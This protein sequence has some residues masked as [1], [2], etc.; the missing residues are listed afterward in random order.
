MI[1]IN[2]VSKA[3]LSRWMV[4]ASQMLPAL[5]GQ[6]FDLITPPAQAAA[7]SCSRLN[8]DVCGTKWYVGGWDGTKGL[9]Q[10]LSALDTIQGLLVKDMQPPLIVPDSR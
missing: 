5:K 9:G 8:N 10:Q 6:V 3:Y 1:P 7:V 4:A 2:L